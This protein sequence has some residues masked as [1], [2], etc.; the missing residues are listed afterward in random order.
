[1]TESE[2]I[3]RFATVAYAAL[4]EA[5]HPD[6]IFPAFIHNGIPYLQFDTDDHREDSPEF[7]MLLR[8][9]ELGQM[10]VQHATG[11]N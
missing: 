8:A 2:T 9:E 7:A 11:D 1:M 3:E 10:A 4:C 6:L 5:G